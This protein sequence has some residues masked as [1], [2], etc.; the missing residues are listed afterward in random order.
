[1]MR[2]VVWSIKGGI[3]TPIIG[4]ET[5]RRAIGLSGVSTDDNPG[6]FPKLPGYSWEFKI[7]NECIDEESEGYKVLWSRGCGC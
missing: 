6:I 1:M 3:E 2:W 5:D 4:R 7:G